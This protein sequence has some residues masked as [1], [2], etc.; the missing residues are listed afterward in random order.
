MTGKT[1]N[2]DNRAASH[3]M[4]CKPNTSDSSDVTTLKSMRRNPEE[5]EIVHQGGNLGRGSYGSV[6]L[7]KD[8]KNG[9]FYAMKIVMKSPFIIRW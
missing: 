2:L 5:F 4:N 9:L 1:L 7:V 3:K 6:K 8:K